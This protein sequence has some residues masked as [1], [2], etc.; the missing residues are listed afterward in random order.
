M[1]PHWTTALDPQRQLPEVAF[2]RTYATT[3]RHGTDGHTRLLLIA[4]LADLLD[5]Y[6]EALEQ[7]TARIAAFEAREAQ[8]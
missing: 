4:A 6:A 1:I 8:P 5:S 7:L 2:A 3:F